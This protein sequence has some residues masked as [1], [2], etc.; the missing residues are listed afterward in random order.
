MSINQAASELPLGITVRE[1]VDKHVARLER[2]EGKGVSPRI[3][4]GVMTEAEFDTPLRPFNGRQSRVRARH[5]GGDGFRRN[6]QRR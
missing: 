2:A 1:L 3:S 5:R 4:M 6:D